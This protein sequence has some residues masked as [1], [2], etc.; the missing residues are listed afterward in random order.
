MIFWQ[1]KDGDIILK[2]G[3][4]L[5]AN[6]EKAQYL[7]KYVEL[8]DSM[9]CDYD[10]IYWNRNLSDYSIQCSGSFISFDEKMDS[11]KHLI[12]KTT[13]Y[14]R[15]SRFV[16]IIIKKNQY[17]KLILFTTPTAVSVLDLCFGKYK[18]KYLFDYRDLTKEYF[19][20]YM[21]LVQKVACLAEVFVTSSPGYLQNFELEKIKKWVLCHN[22]YKD[23]SY[24]KTLK[25]STERPILISY[26]GAVR[27]VE[28]NK[29]V[30]ELFG[31]DK[32]FKF[33]YHG[34]GAYDELSQFCKEKGIEN[35]H[36]TGR[37]LLKEIEKFAAETDILFNAYDTDFVTTPSLAVKVYDSMVYQLPLIVSKDTYMESYLQDYEH[38]FSFSLNNKSVLDELFEWYTNLDK[39]KT[40]HSFEK[41]HS[42]ISE[43][44]M[45]FKKSLEGFVDYEACN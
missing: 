4:L 9:K 18:G 34:E 8:L 37:Y 28:Y 36:F 42:K 30:C 10:V 26:W 23:I 39:D 44:E 5:C 19:K 35:I 3:L 43:D 17:D 14:I 27:Q 21:K 32:R 33:V 2:I 22:T 24:K 45:I 31:N 11:F 12:W 6:L 13:G 15:F 29:K 40:I 1:N 20:P 38:V 16:H 25:L 7:Y 41:L